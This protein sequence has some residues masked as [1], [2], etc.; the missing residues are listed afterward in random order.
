VFPKMGFPVS[1]IAGMAFA[2]VG[3]ADI[4]KR[5]QLLKQNVDRSNR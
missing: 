4:R 1:T 2:T 5:M 3:S